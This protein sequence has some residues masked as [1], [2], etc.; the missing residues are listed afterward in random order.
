[1]FPN[2]LHFYSQ[3]WERVLKHF[4]ND[5]LRLSKTAW[6]GKQNNEER[7]TDS[8]TSSWIWPAVLKILRRRTLG[9]TAF[10]CAFMLLKPQWLWNCNQ[11]FFCI[12]A[13]NY[14]EVLLLGRFHAS[15]GPG[16]QNK[17]YL[18]VFSPTFLSKQKPAKVS[19]SWNMCVCVYVYVCILYIENKNYVL[20]YFSENIM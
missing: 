7:E 1:M 10:S 15:T 12:I 17:Y 5:K 4:V 9:F 13:F 16:P 19:N 3:V 6:G 20:Y 8:L 14:E 18:L 11:I 2:T